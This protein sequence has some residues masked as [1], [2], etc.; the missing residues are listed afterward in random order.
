MVLTALGMLPDARR[1]LDAAT[2]RAAFDAIMDGEIEDAVIADFLTSMADRG[3]TIDEV[4]AAVGALRDR[5]LPVEAPAN[6]VDV[7]GTGGDG[8]HTLNVSTA[9]ALVVAACGVPVAKHGNRAA[10][11]KSG[12]ADVL[13]VLGINLDAEP[14]TIERM[15]SELN[16]GFLF[17]ARHHQA[18]ARV[19]G[20]RRALG[21]RTIFNL[22]GPL[23]NPAGVRRQLVGVFA[24]SWVEPIARALDALGSVHALVVHGSDG[25]DELTVTGPSAVAELVG[26]TV[27]TYCIAPED[28]GLAT[29]SLEAIQG[30]TPE[31][32]A[33][34]LC[35]L[36]AG[37]PGAYRD[38]VLLNAA[39]AL[40]AADA[41]GDWRQGAALA[42]A[43]VDSGRAADLL[44][45][46][47]QFR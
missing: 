44:E 8:R 5:A 47:K 26:G 14:E 46:W 28:A 41:T 39:G 30:G 21:R 38:I 13:G 3:E 7:C 45:R 42:A 27:R 23:A 33:E 2:A 25:L 40:I 18:M 20:V 29:H 32:N 43:A 12:T 16:I 15:L 6:A 10:S 4:V 36:L 9:V 1:P 34:A 22:L 37:K 24:E 17:A 11:S 31:E 19:A 35:A